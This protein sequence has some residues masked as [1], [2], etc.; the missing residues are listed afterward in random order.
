MHEDGILMMGS[1]SWHWITH[2]ID[3][4]NTVNGKPVRYWKNVDGGVVPQGAGQV[5]LANATDVTVEGQDVSNGSVGILLGFSIANTIVG[6]MV[7]WNDDNGIR[8]YRSDSNIIESNNVSASED[9]LVLVLSSNNTI[10]ENFVSSSIE[11][12]LRLSNSHDNTI[13]N[14]TVFEN[15]RGIQ[16]LDSSGN[17][18]FHNNFIGNTNQARDNSVNEWD[19]GYPSGGNHWSDYSGIDNC[20]GPN[21]SVCPDP[22]GIGD[23]NYSFGD[24]G[25]D[26]YPFMEPL[27]LGIVPPPENQHPECEISL[28]EDHAR[29]H[30]TYLITGTASDEDGSIVRVDIRFGNGTWIELQGNETWS[31]EWHTK[32]FDNGEYT[33]YARSF[34]GTNYSAE[35]HVTVDVH[36]PTAEEKSLGQIFFWIALVLVIVIAVGGIALEVRRRKQA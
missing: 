19:D 18:I 32:E 25:L 7:S 14:N 20:S 1:S 13:S 17:R 12:G 16:V 35:V 21:Q 4:L 3:N 10:V 11:D 26:R 6:N 28:P 27:P 30:G 23:T 29:I 34:D 2:T 24:N 5:I 36:N 33:I 31:Y 22:D 8:L 15:Y 9:S